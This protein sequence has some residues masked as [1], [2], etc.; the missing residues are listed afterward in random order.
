MVDISLP[1]FDIGCKCIN[2]F[3]DASPVTFTPQG[4]RIAPTAEIL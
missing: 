2:A 1:L 3:G 4:A